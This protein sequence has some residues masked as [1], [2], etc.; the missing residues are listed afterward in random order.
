MSHSKLTFHTTFVQLRT[1]LWYANR[2]RLENIP[3]SEN[4][5]TDECISQCLILASIND[6]RFRREIY[7][8]LP[9]FIT[10]KLLYNPKE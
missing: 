1:S 6:Y 8:F 5:H 4:F 3:S 7:P 9:N 10:D 2:F